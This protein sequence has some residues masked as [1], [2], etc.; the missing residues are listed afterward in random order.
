MLKILHIKEQLWW[1]PYFSSLKRETVR[2][3]LMSIGTVKEWLACD[4]SELLS[5]MSNSN[6]SFPLFLTVF[7]WSPNFVCPRAYYS[8]H[9]SLS[10]SFLKKDES[11]LLPS[12]FIKEWP[13]ANH[14]CGSLQK[15][16]C[17]WFALVAQDKRATGAICS[18]SWANRCFVNKK[19]VICSKN[20]WV[21][22]SPWWSSSTLALEPWHKK[23]WVNILLRTY[24][25]LSMLHCVCFPLFSD[26]CSSRH[27]DVQG[28]VNELWTFLRMPQHP[29]DHF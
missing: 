25:V 23:S 7:Y 19:R 15:S 12:L 5:K 6:V 13:W 18:F 26:P 29:H 21:K 24:T 28:I 4:L 20:R 14:S 8:R 22:S 17:Y 16:N 27:W 3:S 11:N 1:I 9:S 10:H 2:E